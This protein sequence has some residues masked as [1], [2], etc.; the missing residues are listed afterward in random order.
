MSEVLLTKLAFIYFLSFSD[1]YEKEEY[2]HDNALSLLLP[3]K[4]GVNINFHG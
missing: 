4:Y 2:L 3:L 1:N